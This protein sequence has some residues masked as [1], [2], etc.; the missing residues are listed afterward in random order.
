[1]QFDNPV[2]SVVADALRP[3]LASNNLS[4][5]ALG[6][7]FKLCLLE[8]TTHLPTGDVEAMGRVLKLDPR[9]WRRCRDELI[10]AKVLTVTTAAAA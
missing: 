6:V 3:A 2:T 7:W 8:R 10:D 5:E 9:V 1:M 4:L